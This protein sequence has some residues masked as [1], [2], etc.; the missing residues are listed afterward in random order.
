VAVEYLWNR[1]NPGDDGFK[2][3]LAGGTN[4][5]IGGATTGQASYNTITD[6][7]PDGLKP[8]YQDKSNAW[9]L[10]AF[11]SQAPV[12]DPATSL[13]VVWLFPNDVFYANATATLPGTVPGSPG[14]LNVVANGLANI[15][16]TIQTLALAG[17]RHFLVPNMADLGITPAF[18]G[19][20]LEPALSGLTDLFNGNLHLLLEGLEQGMPGIDIVEFD[21]AGLFKKIAADPNAYGFDVADKSCVANLPNQQ[22]N[23]STWVFWDSVHPT[24]RS[25]QMLAG[26]WQ[27]ALLV[28][29]PPTFMLAVLGLGLVGG[30]ARRQRPGA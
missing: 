9:Q 1:F 5:A 16:T 25:H 19:G 20:P 24:T 28:P 10:A 3:S 7:V 15:Q 21:T 22:C 13:F 26:Y 18:V 4:Y 17:A 11:A 14:G 30:L 23:P 2:P 12:F 29:E 8:A 6:T 27:A